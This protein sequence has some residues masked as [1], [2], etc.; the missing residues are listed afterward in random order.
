MT[1]IPTTEELLAVIASL[2]ADLAVKNNGGVLSLALSK[3][4]LAKDGSVIEPTKGAVSCY[5][6][7]VTFPVTH[8]ANQWEKL[9]VPAFVTKVLDFIGA[10]DAVLNRKGRPFVTDPKTGLAVPYKG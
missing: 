7:N 8:Y 9:Y 2:Q 1:K 6:L 10:N 4:K 3:P 5:G